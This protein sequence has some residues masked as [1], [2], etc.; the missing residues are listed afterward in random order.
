MTLLVQGI[1]SSRREQLVQRLIVGV[2]TSGD[3]SI[4]GVKEEVQS[5]KCS[6]SSAVTKEY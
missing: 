2:H 3:H 6:F 1:L 5:V 4:H